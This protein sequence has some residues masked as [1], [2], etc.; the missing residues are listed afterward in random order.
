MPCLQQWWLFRN[1]PFKNWNSVEK[2]ILLKLFYAFW[3]YIQHILNVII[4][5]NR[6]ILHFNILFK[7]ER[8]VTIF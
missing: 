8:M 2:I 6:Q 7:N 5:L 3:V 4:S 1:I